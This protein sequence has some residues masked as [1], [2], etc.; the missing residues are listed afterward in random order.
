MNR[1]RFLGVAG[2]LLGLGLAFTAG[3]VSRRAQPTASVGKKGCD[4]TITSPALDVTHAVTLR[5]SD[6]LTVA[7]AG[8]AKRCPS[9]TVTLAKSENDGGETSLGTT[10]TNGAGAWSYNLAATDQVTTLFSARMTAGSITTQAQASV[11]A[12]R[13]LPKVVVTAPAADDWGLLR[14]VAAKADAGCGSGG[15]GHVEQGEPGWL[16]DEACADGGQVTPSVTVTGA[17]GGNLFVLYAGVVLVDAGLTTSP[18][19]LGLAELGQ[20]TL[21]EFSR[22]DLVFRAV[23]GQGSTSQTLTTRVMTVAPSAP[24]GP[25]GGAWV[26]TIL[27]N[28]R[29]TVAVDYQVPTVPA[30]VT[31]AHIEGAWTTAQVLGTGNS[32]VARTAVNVTTSATLLADPPTAA[33]QIVRFQPCIDD[34]GVARV[35]WC[36]T[37]SGVTVGAGVRMPVYAVTDGGTCAAAITAFLPP[38]Y[39]IGTS[40][41][42]GGLT[43]SLGS[44]SLNRDCSGL[45]YPVK[46]VYCVAESGFANVT[47]SDD[48]MCTDYKPAGLI[49]NGLIQRQPVGS[50]LG[51]ATGVKRDCELMDETTSPQTWNCEGVTYHSGDTR[52]FVFDGLPPLNTYHFQLVTVF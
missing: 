46:S 32:A 12:D 42:D 47:P 10:S 27:N 6:S 39:E 24:A 38:N 11:R 22:A 40:N 28:R 15:N 21:A 9:A 20:L 23:N 3:Q 41:A 8:T 30:G 25:D 17:D 2:A 19:T 34:G 52:S 48:G 35:L 16:N 29:A 31:A 50:Y 51:A 13:R 1:R 4:V 49:H 14:I 26:T 18:Q 7:F 33:R 5:S 44:N 37:T 36:D 43:I 45:I